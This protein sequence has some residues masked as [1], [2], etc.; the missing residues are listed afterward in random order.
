MESPAGYRGEQI[1]YDSLALFLSFMYSFIIYLDP[2]FIF[3]VF[4]NS[5]L[6]AAFSA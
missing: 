5:V 2:L 3:T 6:Y 1:V 4:Y